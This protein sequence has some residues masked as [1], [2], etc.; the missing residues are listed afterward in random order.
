MFSLNYLQSWREGSK[1]V[2]SSCPSCLGIQRI[3]A[4]AASSLNNLLKSALNPERHSKNS[5]ID[6]PLAVSESFI[7]VAIAFVLWLSASVVAEYKHQLSSLGGAIVVQSLSF[8]RIDIGLPLLPGYLCELCLPILTHAQEVKGG[9]A[10]SLKLQKQSTCV[11]SNSP[12][13]D[14]T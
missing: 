10:L 11:D 4:L 5:S 1:R 14:T 3:R 6:G 12:E 8:A 13:A 9:V 2:A 7:R